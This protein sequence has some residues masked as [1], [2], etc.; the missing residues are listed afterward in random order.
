MIEVENLR[1]SFGDF[2][3][4]RG[5]SFRIEK[6]E[7]VGLLGPNG[8]GK[9]TTMRMLTGFYNPTAGSIHVAGYSLPEQKLEA[10]KKIGYLPESSSSYPDMIVSDFLRFVGEARDLNEKE[11]AEG[12]DRGVTAAGLEKYYYRPISQLSKGYKQRVGLAAALIHNPDILILDEPT[13]GLDPNQIAEIQNLIRELGKEKT[14]ILS[15]HILKEVEATCKRAIIIHEGKIVS[16]ASLEELQTKKEGQ[17]SLTVSIKGKIDP[18]S[19][20]REKVTI[21]YVNT[22]PGHE[23]LSRFEISG[24]ADLPEKIFQLAVEQGWVLTE[25]APQKQSLEDVFQMLTGGQK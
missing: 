24:P 5:I 25:L 2:E 16:D 22:L 12:I 14:I 21:D 20:L 19:V 17:I 23:E 15:T 9:T 18:S 1:K 13:A 10:Q 7:V 6:G 11:L 4:V 8:A 3:A